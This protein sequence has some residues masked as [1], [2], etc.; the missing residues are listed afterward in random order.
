MGSAILGRLGGEIWVYFDPVGPNCMGLFKPGRPQ[1][2]AWDDCK[3]AQALRW[4][5]QSRMD[6]GIA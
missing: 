1:L 5:L 6:R 4:T 2:P 3:S